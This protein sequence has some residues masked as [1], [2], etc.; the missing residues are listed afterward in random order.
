LGH[1]I[2]TPNENGYGDSGNMINRNDMFRTGL[3][4]WAIIATRLAASAQ[5]DGRFTT[6]EA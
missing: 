5:G 4:L 3:V 6:S 1:G 2:A